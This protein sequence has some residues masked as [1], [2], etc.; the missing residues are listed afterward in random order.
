M[1]AQPLGNQP[2]ASISMTSNDA[3]HK[4]MADRI[5]D[6]V[7][8][9]MTANNPRHLRRIANDVALIYIPLKFF[10]S[11]GLVA[12]LIE[13]EHSPTEFWGLINAEIWQSLSARSDVVSSKSDRL[14]ITEA[15][16]TQAELATLSENTQPEN[17]PA[18]LS[19]IIDAFWALQKLDICLT[20]LM[21]IHSRDLQ[22]QHKDVTHWLCLAIKRYLGEWQSALFAND[23]V[24]RE[25]LSKPPES[26]QTISME[27]LDRRHGL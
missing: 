24:L 12:S 4:F 2:L 20:A 3:L 1:A 14:I 10:I 9:L 6:A 11:T 21:A 8:P 26:I 15:L 5:L 19:A 27:E 16:K 23:P 18:L 13:S 7:K 22:P 25:R 17:K